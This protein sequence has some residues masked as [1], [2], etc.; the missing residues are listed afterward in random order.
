MVPI[1]FDR[2]LTYDELVHELKRLVDEHSGLARLHSIG[3]SYEGRELWMVEITNRSTGEADRKPGYY[4]DGNLHAGEVTGSTAALYTI[5]YLLTRYGTDPEVT[6][7]VD[8]TTFYVL[9]RVSPDGA[10]RYLTT[11][12]TVRSSVRLYPFEEEQD[13]L[14]PEDL[15]GDGLILQM[16]VPDADGE[17]KISERDRRLMIPRLP[18]ERGGQYYR[19]HV[20]GTI[21]H[22][23]GVSVKP[24][25]GRCQLDLNRQFPVAW[26]PDVKQ[27]GAG[28]YPLSE[29]ETRAVAEFLL[30]QTNITGG[31][32]FHTATGIILRPSSLRSDTKM[33][34]KDRA[35][36][37]ALG[38]VGERLTGYPCVS[39]YDGYAYDKENPI[40]GCFLDWC[41]D[42]LG[43]L[44]YSTELWDIRVR[45][46]L[47][48]VS[49]GDGAKSVDAEA[50][51]LAL[52][53][54]NDRELG[55]EGFV[56]WYDFDHPQLGRVQLGGWRTK[57]VLQNAPSRF[58][59]AEA[60]KNAIFALRHAAALPHLG[61][62]RLQAEHLGNG[63]HRVEAV[64]KNHG[65]LPTNITEMALQ[66]KTARPVTVELTL[67]D[68]AELVLGKAKE[69]IGQLDGR[70]LTPGGFYPGN[71]SPNQ[72]AR[73]L[74]WV[75]RCPAG[76]VLTVTA[77]GQK[78]GEAAGEVRLEAA[79]A[80]GQTGGDRDDR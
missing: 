42:N 28:P 66:N 53:T 45:A 73:R 40:K 58:L 74:E 22:Y 20:E 36:F 62:D 21:R 4:I 41:Y 13:G 37:T 80:C 38:E 8:S 1:D 32:S 59:R 12:H 76:G 24:A 55:G 15:D 19:L 56:D 18:H 34:P 27:P 14:Q 31:Q 46:G 48:R 2:F 11:P 75:V 9:P 67:P 51:G 60:H 69:E 3:R 79:E 70:I 17:W 68:G 23:D 65:Y 63:V 57:E 71:A 10:E 7:L 49:F 6:A 29:P 78:A 77:S 64:V 61:L 44:L 52:L 72:S 35:A 47:S 25:P 39:V 5:W 30:K 43:L 33:S 54:F 16:R 50:E 26:E